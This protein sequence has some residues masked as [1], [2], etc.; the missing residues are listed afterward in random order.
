MIFPTDTGR[1][2]SHKIVPWAA[3]NSCL[4]GKEVWEKRENLYRQVLILKKT[5]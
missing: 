1:I 5:H 4:M 2:E 3:T